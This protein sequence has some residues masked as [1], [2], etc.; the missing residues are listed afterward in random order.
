M[1]NHAR[2]PL[3]LTPAEREPAFAFMSRVAAVGGTPAIDFGQDIGVPFQKILDGASEAIH[4]LANLA[5]TQ[6]DE[7]EA[8]QPSK[9]SRTKR[10]LAG[11]LFPRV[12]G[13]SS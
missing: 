10:K 2:S 9:V 4:L 12:C 13:H 5:G 8:W 3:H 7:L 11:H 1:I 6:A